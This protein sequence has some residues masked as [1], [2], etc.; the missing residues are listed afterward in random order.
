M[1]AIFILSELVPNNDQMS[2]SFTA[3][4][5]CYSY[6]SNTVLS[7]YLTHLEQDRMPTV[8]LR[9]VKYVLIILFKKTT[10][11]TFASVLYVAREMF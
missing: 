5:I 8:W 3:S 2:S 1:K 10:E 4:D 11:Q 9:S 7:F 6:Q